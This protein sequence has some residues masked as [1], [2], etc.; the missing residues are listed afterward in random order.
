[1]LYT[2]IRI[3]NTAAALYILDIITVQSLQWITINVMENSPSWEVN[4]CSATHLFLDF[5]TTY[6][7]IT[8]F[9]TTWLTPSHL[10]SLAHLPSV[11]TYILHWT[12]MILGPI[13]VVQF[14]RHADT[15]KWGVKKWDTENHGTSNLTNWSYSGT[16]NSQQNSNLKN[17]QPYPKIHILN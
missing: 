10:I 1:M 13:C 12:T 8:A 6:E 3:D 17:Q 11:L 9:T 7:F 5:H 14:K 2:F 16:N 15:P 4:S